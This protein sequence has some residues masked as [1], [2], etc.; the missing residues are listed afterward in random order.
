MPILHPKLNRISLF[1]KCVLH[2]NTVHVQ[3]YVRNF[4]GFP[5]SGAAVS[6][7]ADENPLAEISL[8]FSADTIQKKVSF[9]PY[10]VPTI[11]ELVQLI[12]RDLFR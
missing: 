11:S 9:P 4:L 5:T 10:L 12:G 6:E 8:K 1:G 3:N 7:A 2:L